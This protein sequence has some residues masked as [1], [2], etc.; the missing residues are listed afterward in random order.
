MKANLGIAVI[1]FLLLATVTALGQSPVHKNGACP[2]GYHSDGQY[3]VPGRSAKPVIDKSGSCPSGYHTDGKY[4]VA[5]SSAREAILKS[6]SCPSGY[7]S[8][9]NYCV[10]T[11]R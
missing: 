10:R 2:S 5:G 11:R 9:G 4:C 7:H 3:C 6:G 1:S 8:D